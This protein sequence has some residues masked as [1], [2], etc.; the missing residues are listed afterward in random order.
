MKLQSIFCVYI[1]TCISIYIHIYTQ[2]FEYTYKH[3]YALHL[4][5]YL[6]THIH[7]HINTYIRL[8]Q[9]QH[10]CKMSY[11]IHNSDASI[12]S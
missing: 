7:T 9:P 1:Y 12:M 11:G 10:F 8:S 5:T 2:T 3:A 6:H 4:H